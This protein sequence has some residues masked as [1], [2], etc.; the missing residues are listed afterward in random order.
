MGQQQLLLII[1]GVFVVGIAIAIGIVM[2]EDNA[3]SQ[4][5]DAV[6]TDLM[7][8][9]GKARHYYGRPKS[10]G[11]GGHSFIGITMG[12]LVTTAFSDNANGIYS[13]KEGSITDNTVTFVGLGKVVGKDT[14]RLELTITAS[15]SGSIKLVPATP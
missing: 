4:N 9:A 11:G 1:L 6:S 14:T 3:V 5:R 10:M 13:I 15:G 8:L 2:F 7:H 12:A